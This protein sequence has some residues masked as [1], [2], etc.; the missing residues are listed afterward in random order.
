MVSKPRARSNQV[1]Q[2]INTA[3][4]LLAAGK[5]IMDA[6]RDLAR[7][8]QLSERQARRYVQRARVDGTI[9]V[10][11]PKV[12]F[13]V[14]VPLALVQGVRRLAKATGQSISGLVTQALGEFLE[15][16]GQGGTRG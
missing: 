7:H 5:D 3:A 4:G 6:T 15:H 16:H 2:R 13:T 11:G 9:E 8:Y 10:P 14:K 1:A 12:V